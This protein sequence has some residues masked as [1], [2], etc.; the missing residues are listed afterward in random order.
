MIY[1]F[2]SSRTEPYIHLLTLT[3]RRVEE[4]LYFTQS[5]AEC[6]ESL[7]IRVEMKLDLADGF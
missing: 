7:G 5:D 6:L 4:V 2:F 3:G 1:R